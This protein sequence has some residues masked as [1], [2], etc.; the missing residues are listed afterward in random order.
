[1]C[2]TVSLWT[3]TVDIKHT[4][5]IHYA[6][7]QTYMQIHLF[8]SLV[9]GADLSPLSFPRGCHPFQGPQWFF[10]NKWSP[11]LLL[12]GKT[13]QSNLLIQWFRNTHLKSLECTCLQCSWC[14][15]SSAA[16]SWKPIGQSHA[17]T[18]FRHFFCF[19]VWRRSSVQKICF[20]C[21]IVHNHKLCNFKLKHIINYG[22]SPSSKSTLLFPHLLY[23]GDRKCS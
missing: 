11:S 22:D 1:M 12:M 20:S 7:A 6:M 16:S 9:N 19:W 13:V 8:S 17:P 10:T 5:V 2:Q 21:I 3:V 18:L 4:L 14:H 15:V 23:H